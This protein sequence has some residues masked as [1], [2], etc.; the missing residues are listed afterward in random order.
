MRQ[1]QQLGIILH[2]VM[3]SILQNKVIIHIIY[4]WQFKWAIN[5]AG[6]MVLLGE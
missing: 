3:L 4:I 5:A 6:E 2:M 1:Q